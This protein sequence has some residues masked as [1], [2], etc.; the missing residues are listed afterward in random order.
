MI[1]RILTATIAT[2][3]A[4]TAFAQNVKLSNSVFKEGEVKSANGKIE[5]KLLP[6]NIVTPGDKIIFVMGYSNAGT[7]AAD[8]VTITNPVPSQVTYLGGD[9]ENEPIVSVDGGKAFGALATLTIKNADGS[10][11][12]ARTSDVTHV[13][14][15]FARA[16][17]PGETGQVSYRGQLK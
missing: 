17:N 7:K 5:R 15:Q 14:W 6:A 4:T 16:L 10:T 12:P 13:R 8:R 9:T 1:K 2:L 3:I 11:R